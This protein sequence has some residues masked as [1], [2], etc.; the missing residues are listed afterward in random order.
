MHKTIFFISLFVLLL[1]ACGFKATAPD[2]VRPTVFIITATLPPTTPPP[3]AQATQPATA[4]PTLT[5][6]EGTTSSKVNVRAEPSTAGTTLA[7]VDQF[8]K[9]QITGKDPGGN[10]YQIIFP[11][12]PDGKGWVTAQYVEVK[13]KDAIKVIGAAPASTSGNG[14]GSISGPSGV[15]I[16]QVNVRSGPGTDFDTL[17]TLN[18]KDVV[19]LIGK[20]ANGM[21]LQ[22]SFTNAPDGKGWVTAAYVQSSGAENLPI[23]GGGGQVVGT[24]TPTIIPPTITPT[25]VAALQDNDSQQ[26]PAVSIIFSPVGTRSLIYSS[27]VSAPD[28]DAEDWVQ[29]T[30]Y[31]AS[32]SISLTCAGNGA[33]NVELWQNGA[34]SQN[35]AGLLCGQKKILDVIAG[36]MY[37]VRLFVRPGNNGLEYVNYTLGIETMR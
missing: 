17:G 33:L 9:I 3:P 23:V 10:W 20:D 37:L 13:D 21:W 32:V 8:A 19:T 11:Q 24:G 15:I 35:W 30:P 31:S 22:I 26:A 16:Q 28:G 14:S 18:P 25:L 7:I 5:P 2:S 6:V 1:S 4:L 34:T 29:F 12:G 36:Q 27:N